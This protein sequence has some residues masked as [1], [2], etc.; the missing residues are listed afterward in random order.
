ME[1]L[2]ERANLKGLELVCDIDDNIPRFLSGDMSRLRLV[3]MNLLG[4]ALKFTEQGEVVVHASRIG[5]DDV[6]AYV[7]IEVPTPESASHQT[8]RNGYSES[9]RKRMLPRVVSL[10][11]LA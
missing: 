2:A 4:N 8:S 10:A 7:R 1:L 11:V 3:L 6:S 9:S 5:S